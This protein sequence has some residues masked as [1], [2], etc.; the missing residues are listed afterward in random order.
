[1]FSIVGQCFEFPSVPRHGWLTGT[2]SGPHKNVLLMPKCRLSE[3]LEE[4]NQGE[5]T[6]LDS[7]GNSHYNRGGGTT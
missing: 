4:S 3:Q 5:L 6:N 2:A 1:M 7:P